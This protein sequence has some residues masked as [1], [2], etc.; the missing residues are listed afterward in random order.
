MNLVSIKGTKATVGY[1]HFYAYSIHGE[2][3]IS[4]HSMSEKVPRGVEITADQAEELAHMLMYLA[5]VSRQITS[6]VTCNPPD[7][8]GDE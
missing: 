7:F 5:Q 6:Q 8:G 2:P 3:C 1:T 4:I